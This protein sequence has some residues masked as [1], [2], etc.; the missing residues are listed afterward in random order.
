MGIGVTAGR[1]PCIDRAQL[2]EQRPLDIESVGERQGFG[3]ITVP[4]VGEVGLDFEGK[5]AHAGTPKI[6]TAAR[7]VR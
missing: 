3:R 6:A 7:N 1:A 2:L 4:E 5:A